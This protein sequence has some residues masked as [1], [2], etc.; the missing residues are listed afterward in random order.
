ML[1]RLSRRSRLKKAVLICLIASFA[2]LFFLALLHS[3]GLSPVYKEKEEYHPKNGRFIHNRH[4]P[5][6]PVGFN[7]LVSRDVLVAQL[8]KGQPSPQYGGRNGS[9][10]RHKAA[11]VQ[12]PCHC[13]STQSSSYPFSQLKGDVTDSF[14]I[15]LLTFNR[16]DLL[17]RLLNH[18]SAMPHLEK[19]IVVCNAV[20]EGTS[21]EQE[22][23]ELGPHPVP[24]EFKVQMENRLRNRLQLFPN[25][26]SSGMIII[27]ACI[28]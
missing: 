22:W 6:N 27:A 15:V 4:L 17:L 16:S 23:K 8:K 26:K 7:K 20:D 11:S 9:L 14:S 19:I 1:H 21:S 12:E 18:Y 3:Q 28:A 10:S 2:L 24:V 5:D 13:N 25:I